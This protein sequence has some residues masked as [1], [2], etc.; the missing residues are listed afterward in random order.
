MRQDRV[1]RK[2]SLSA[3]AR[4]IGIHPAELSG[5]EHGTLRPF[6]YEALKI[7]MEPGPGALGKEKA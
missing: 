4:R 3:E 1:A 2:L 7:Q 6:D 5:M